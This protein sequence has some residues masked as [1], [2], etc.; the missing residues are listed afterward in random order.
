MHASEN[1]N[2]TNTWLSDDFWNKL[3]HPEELSITRPGFLLLKR[4]GPGGTDAAQLV[5]LES[6]EGVKSECI[7]V[8]REALQGKDIAPLRRRL[9]EAL[10]IHV[11][12]TKETHLLNAVIAV[13]TPLASPAVRDACVREGVGLFDLSGTMLVHRGPVF[14]HVE[15][16]KK[17]RRK[18]TTPLFRGGAARALRVLLAQPS[19]RRSATELTTLANLSVSYCW[20]VLERLEADGFVSRRTPRSGYALT[21]PSAL[22][23]AWMNSGEKSWTAIESFNVTQT[24]AAFLGQVN[25]ALLERGVDFAWTMSAATD[26]RFV[27]GLPV[28]LY[29]SADVAALVK[30]LGLRKVT[31]FNF[32]VLRA[33]PDAA[34]KDGGVYL[35][36]TRVPLFQLIIDFHALGGRG[37]EQAE[38]LFEQWSRAL[39]VLNE[40]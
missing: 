27:F 13:S 14:L 21:D 16:T 6:Y 5:T 37:E 35:S 23:R 29:C 38:H 33:P 32:H 8:H 40:E 34:T 31:P 22:L 1:H 30:P 26:E 25:R 28:G 20:R 2:F 11:R 18:Q 15:G 10:E 4:A 36:G 7:V 24:D 39:P 9:R 19:E 17:V 3:S 12:R